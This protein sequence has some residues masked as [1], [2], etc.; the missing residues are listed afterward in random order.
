MAL[1]LGEEAQ[2]QLEQILQLCPQQD[3]TA[4]LILALAAPYVALLRIC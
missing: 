3:C 4:A 1:S 2:E